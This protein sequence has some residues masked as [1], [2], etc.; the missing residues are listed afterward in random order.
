MTTERW[1]AFGVAAPVGTDRRAVRLSSW[2]N[3][4]GAPGG[5]ALPWEANR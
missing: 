4:C 1:F 3:P 5:R 2:Q